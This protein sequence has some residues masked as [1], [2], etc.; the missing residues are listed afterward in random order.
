VAR[1]PSRVILPII[2]RFNGKLSQW[3]IAIRKH[4]MDSF[5][6]GSK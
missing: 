4:S 3:A 5:V 2:K 6:K 1:Y